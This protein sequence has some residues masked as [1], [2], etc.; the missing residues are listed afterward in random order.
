MRNI[1]K[2]ESARLE[3]LLSYDILDTVPEES[4]DR[5]TRLAK[6]IFEA[7]VALVSLVDG[8]RQWFKSNQGLS[9]CE[10]PRDIS[11]CTHAIK[12]N[13][14]L[15]IRDAL[16][17]PAFSNNPLVVGAPHVR[18]YIGAPLRTPAGFNIGSL[19]V[20]DYVPR[21]PTKSQVDLLEDLAK[22]VVDQLEL[23]QIATTD[24]LTGVLTRREL[25]SHGQKE[26]ERHRRYKRPFGVITFD[27]DYFKKINDNYGHPAG[28]R[29][30]QEVTTMCKK[31]LRDMDK[32]G[33]VGG[34]E[35]TVFLPEANAETSR[36]VAERMRQAV[37]SLRIN[38]GQNILAVTA[39]FGIAEAWERDKTLTDTIGRADK[40]LYFAKRAGRNRCMK[41]QLENILHQGQAV[42]SLCES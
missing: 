36:V 7:P 5:I 20:I 8:D 27:L 33:R 25:L 14:P 31:Q 1:S 21:E 28:D 26:F 12:H 23:R 9:V 3:N 6:Y 32:I 34:E 19:C 22:L 4:F 24:S 40:V 15:I 17:Y 38:I 10:T 11:F 37:E 35:F 13:E 18:F 2:L 29:V 30:L 16:K 39:S 42:A 41:A